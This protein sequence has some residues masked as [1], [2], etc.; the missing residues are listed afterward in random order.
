VLERRGEPGLGRERP[1][2][3]TRPDRRFHYI[4]ANLRYWFL[5]NRA[6][7]GVEYLH[8]RKQARSGARES[9]NPVHFA[10]RFDIPR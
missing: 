9:A 5:A 10:I 4:A 6:W 7:A 8:G 3:G 2:G 1:R